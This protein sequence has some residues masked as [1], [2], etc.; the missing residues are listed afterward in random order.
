MDVN[1]EVRNASLPNGEAGAAMLACG[2]GVCF[3]GVMVVLAETSSS[4]SQVLN[5][6]KP[7]GPL[8]GKFAVGIVSWL[9]SWG[10]LQKLWGRRQINFRKVRWIA[11]ALIVVGFAMTFPPVFGLFAQN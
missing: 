7:V 4:V 6:M 3:F 2:I 8:S 10:I 11:L 5:L 9:V 1:S